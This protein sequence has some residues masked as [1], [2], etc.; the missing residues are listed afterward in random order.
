M[1]ALIAAFATATCMPILSQ[2]MASIE[3][4]MGISFVYGFDYHHAQYTQ[5]KPNVGF[6]FGGGMFTGNWLMLEYEIA[7]EHRYYYNIIKRQLNGKN[8]LHK[9]ANFTSI[10]PSWAYITHNGE[11]GKVNN[12][13][14]YCSINYGLRRTISNRFYFDGS[15]GIGPVYFKNESSWGALGNIYLSVG[16]Q[17]F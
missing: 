15:I 11:L 14:Y 12:Y 10:K 13:R 3:M 9:S 8:T 1:K 6:A 4:P 2:N 5:V 7:V 17:L 16:F